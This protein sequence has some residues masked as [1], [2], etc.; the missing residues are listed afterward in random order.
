MSYFLIYLSKRVS[1]L[2]VQAANN[3]AVTLAY[4]N[5]IFIAFEWFF[6]QYCT[7]KQIGLLSL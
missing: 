7:L 5:M 6:T 1:G 4:K 3:W 2:I